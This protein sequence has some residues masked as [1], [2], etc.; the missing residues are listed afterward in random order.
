MSQDYARFLG[1]GPTGARGPTGPQGATGPSGGGGGGGDT[2]WQL[3]G[4]RSLPATV[5]VTGQGPDVDIQ[6]NDLI[7]L[8]DTLGGTVSC[9][10]T[11]GFFVEPGPVSFKK[12]TATCNTGEQSQVNDLIIEA[13]GDGGLVQ[14]TGPGRSFGPFLPN[15]ALHVGADCNING[16]LLVAGILSLTM[17]GKTSTI[18]QLIADSQADNGTVI[19]NGI[20]GLVV[21]NGPCVIG[22]TTNV[23][24]DLHVSGDATCSALA[25]TTGTGHSS[26]INNL[27]VNSAAD[28]GTVVVANSSN[29]VVTGVSVLQGTVNTNNDVHVGGALTVAGSSGSFNAIDSSGSIRAPGRF[30]RGGVNNAIHQ[31]STDQTQTVFNDTTVTPGAVWQIINSPAPIANEWIRF[32]NLSPSAAVLVRNPAGVNLIS[33]VFTAGNIFAVTMVFISGVWTIVDVSFHP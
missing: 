7:I 30:V 24:G 31:F 32:I 18:N 29:L 9:I 5:Q 13:H 21:P 20:G 16:N 12:L 28:G 23:G 1:I 33:L 17:S 6:L 14:C 25:S 3:G 4:V 26:V 22:G 2:L 19:A 11:G 10:G 27:V 15:C 8:D